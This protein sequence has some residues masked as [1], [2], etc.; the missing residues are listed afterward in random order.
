MSIT[1]AGLVVTLTFLGLLSLSLNTVADVTE[2]TILADIDEANKISDNFSF[3]M[4]IVVFKENVKIDKQ[5]VVGYVSVSDKN[6][7]SSLIAF[8]AP[9][10]VK[11]RKMLIEGNYIWASFP[12]TR[13]LIRLSPLQVMLGD[14]AYGDVLRILYD[15][16]YDV[17]AIKEFESNA[18]RYL[19]LTL[20]AKPK[21]RGLG[22]AGIVL[23]VFKDDLKLS[24]ARLYGSSG[25]H[26]KTAIFSEHREFLGK[27]VPTKVTIKSAINKGSTSVLL[28]K[29]IEH[30]VLPASFYNKSVL[31][32]I[33]LDDL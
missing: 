23:T 32:R 11:G 26:M 4:D 2:S 31:N 30:K 8:H 29:D 20:D 15:Q 16:N 19:E 13:N 24:E 21:S 25:K 12:R 27:S 3:S 7:V 28:Y 10:D 17:S 22:Y 1:R 14:V 5:E 6:V 18:G 33:E 9:E